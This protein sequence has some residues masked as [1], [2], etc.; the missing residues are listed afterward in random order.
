MHVNLGE[1]EPRVEA[2]LPLPCTGI[3]RGHRSIYIGHPDGIRAFG[4][5]LRRAAEADLEIP[6][7]DVHDVKVSPAG[8]LVVAETGLNRLACYTGTG[9]AVSV[10]TPTVEGADRCHLNSTTFLNGALLVAMFDAEGRGEPWGER[11]DGVIAEANLLRPGE[12]KPLWAGVE[13]PHSLVAV[14]G[15][16]WW[17]DSRRCRVMRNGT[18]V[19]RLSGYT[20]GLAVTEAWVVVGQSR[21]DNHSVKFEGF[22]S[23]AVWCYPREGRGLGE[24]LVVEL[25]STEVYDVLPISVEEAFNLQARLLAQQSAVPVPSPPRPGHAPQHVPF[26]KARAMPTSALRYRVQVDLSK[27]E[28][29]PAQI[30]IL[31][32][33]NKRVLEVGPATG[34]I[35]EAL[36]KRGCRVTA[37]ENDRVAAESAAQFCERMIVGDVEQIDFAAAFQGE[38]FDVVVFGEVLEHL[39]DPHRA[40]LEAAKALRPGGYV[41]ASVPNVAH[42][43]VRLTLLGGAFPYTELGLLDHTHLRFFTRDTLKNLFKQAGYVIRVWRRIAMDPFSTE[44]NLREGAYPSNLVASLRQDPEAMTYQYV[45]KAYPVARNRAAKEWVPAHRPT[46]RPAGEPLRGLWQLQQD[47]ARQEAELTEQATALSERG[48]LLAEKDRALAKMDGISRE[49]ARARRRLRAQQGELESLHHRLGEI[50]NSRGWQMLQRVR[51]VIRV[52]APRGS[53]R[54]R[55]L[56]GALRAGAAL[57]RARPLRQAAHLVRWPLQ[58]LPR[59]LAAQQPGAKRPRVRKLRVGCYGEHCWTVGGGTV[60]AIQLLMPLTPYYD[61]HLLL[62]PGVPMRDRQWYQDNLL[63]DMGDIEVRPYANGVEDTY[64]VWLS[65]WNEHIWPAKTAKCLNMVFFP[66]VSLDGAG[67]THITVSNYSDAYVRERYE[68]DDVVVIYPCIDASEFRTGPKEPMILH[69]SR[70]ALPS[71]F[72][73]K[74]HVTMIQAFKQLCKRGLTGWRLVLAGASLDEGEVAYAAHLAKHAYGFPIELRQNLSAQ[75]LRDL[76]ARAS[77]YWHATGFSVNEPAAQEHFGITILE[78]MA[79]GAVPIVLNSGGPP[80]IISS[81]EHGYLFNSKEELVE[82][83]RE[84]ASRP[85]LWKRLSRAAR[86]RVVEAFGPDKTRARMLSTV[87][88]TEKVSIIIGTHNNL[89]YLKGTVESLLRTTPPGFELIIVDNGSSDGTGVYL[90]SL[91][92][93]QLRVIRNRGNQGFAVFNNQGQRAA[94]RPYILYLNDDMELAFGWLEPLIEMLDAHPQVGAVGS[95]LLYPDGRVYHDGKMFIREDLTPHHIGMGEKPSRD[96]TPIEVDTL[97]ANA[98]L[99]RRELAGFSPDYRRGYYEDTDLCMRIKAQGH[100]LVLHRGSVAIHYHGMTM[101]RDQAAT[102]RA[103]ARNRRLFLKRWAEQL[104]SLVYLASRKEIADKAL[105]CRPLLPPDELAD[106]WPLSRR[107]ER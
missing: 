60:Y 9:A 20:R 75:E 36:Q 11:L 80:E 22:G 28:T 61:V 27:K 78:G 12:F 16:L 51:P 71:A 64:D 15:E 37:I 63:M 65:V 84:V 6:G 30:V 48:A 32:G 10:W 62:P 13:H 104:P 2:V 7:S 68:A 46:L 39:V 25:P 83:T 53:L 101:G 33:S 87:G 88:K 74:A 49:L 81:G 76:F 70:F 26:E 96:Q 40:L 67:Y 14:D 91:D 31:T 18:E 59:R 77:I 43:S 5:D 97:T 23:C 105:R 69:V 56:M 89:R 90:A 52:V 103:Q 35:T 58:K 29:Q 107:L 98:L 34:Y 8:D 54:F 1:S 106:A 82:Y 85:Q 99:V 21:S 3:A 57:L 100:A 72:A 55:L 92:Y 47:F 50:E 42:A 94:T 4:P 41:V 79:S 24:P 17:C 38:L 19:A 73:D 86:Q 45:V 102:E 66:F 93:P 95:R 44:L